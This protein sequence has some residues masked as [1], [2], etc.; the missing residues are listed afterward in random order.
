MNEFAN[1]IIESIR[2]LFD[3]KNSFQITNPLKGVMVNIRDSLSQISLSSAATDNQVL[4]TD[5]TTDDEQ[6]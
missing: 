4:S 2:P 1:R 3:F 5:A 6:T